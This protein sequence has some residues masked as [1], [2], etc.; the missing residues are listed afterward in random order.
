[1]RVQARTSPEEMEETANA[2]AEK[3]NGYA[4]KPMVKFVIPRKGFSSLSVEGGALHDPASDEVFVSTLRKS[5]DPA[6]KVFEVDS[7]INS[8]EFAGVVADALTEAMGAA[9]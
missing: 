2:V 1:M 8:R 3:L 4:Y 6:I 5:L 9:R 7:D